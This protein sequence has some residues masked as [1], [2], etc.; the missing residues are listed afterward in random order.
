[1]NEAFEMLALANTHEKKALLDASECL[2]DADGIRHPE[3]LAFVHALQ[4]VLN[5][6]MAL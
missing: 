5:G 1:L 4:D 6:K 3:E 2:V